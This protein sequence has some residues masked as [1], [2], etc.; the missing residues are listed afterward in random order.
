M[1]RDSDGK[2]SRQASQSAEA[3]AASK[4]GELPSIPKGVGVDLT[5]LGILPL[6]YRHLITATAECVVLNR[7]SDLE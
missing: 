1:A 6:V 4:E 2:R 5:A 7:S 3:S